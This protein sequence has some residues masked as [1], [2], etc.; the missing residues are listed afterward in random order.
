M[1]RPRLLPSPWKQYNT[2]AQ[3]LKLK[4]LIHPWL[5]GGDHRADYRRDAE[6]R[7]GGGGRR[8]ATPGAVLH[9]RHHVH[10][11]A[12]RPRLPARR[13]QL[14]RPRVLQEHRGKQKTLARPANQ[15]VQKKEPPL[16][17]AAASSES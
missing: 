17:R 15:L 1:T 10:G 14:E 11:P 9:H 3:G 4:L 16:R 8:R 12:P 5:A 2:R 6:R 7:G 13:L